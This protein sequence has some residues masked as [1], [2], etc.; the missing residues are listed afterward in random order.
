VL[1]YSKARELAEKWV[2][3]TTDC[4]CKIVDVSDKSYGWVFFYQMKDFDQNDITTHAA[5]NSPLIVNRF[6]CEIRTTGTA[7][8][9][10]HYLKE[11]EATLPPACLEAAP[12]R[13]DGLKKYR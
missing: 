9:I 6:D 7:Q 2:A 3:L 11:Y 4:A 10:E 12:E 8:P 5:G 13:H 1:S